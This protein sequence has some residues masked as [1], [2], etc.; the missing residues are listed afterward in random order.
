MLSRPVLESQQSA[1]FAPAGRA[2]PGGWNILPGRAL[3]L[4]PRERS[5]IEM[6]QG[7]LWLTFT[8]PHHGHAN[9]LGDRFLM[10]GD[11]L[12]VEAGQTV[13]LEAFVLAQE[14]SRERAQAAPVDVVFRW[15]RALP[16]VASSQHLPQ[17]VSAL[18]TDLALPLADL[19]RG[20][21]QGWQAAGAVLGALGRLAAGSARLGWLL[22][23][24]G[25]QRHPA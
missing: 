22:L 4:C 7:R 8:G 13:V 12:V 10:A 1:A 3:T 16:L 20:L 25:R 19:S 5:V 18:P 2:F 15:D 24:G 21:W 11:W 6:N 17:P 9:D 23:Q 14:M